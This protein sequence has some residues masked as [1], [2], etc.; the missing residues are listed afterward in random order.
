[1]GARKTATIIFL[2]VVCLFAIAGA[3]VV[4]LTNEKP[5]QIA[6]SFLYCIVFFASLVAALVVG[7]VIKD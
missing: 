3:F 5:I 1:M 4:P 6:W 2:V 7:D